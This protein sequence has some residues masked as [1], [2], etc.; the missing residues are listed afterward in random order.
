[1]SKQD[2][3]DEIGAIVGR[4][5]RKRARETERKRQKLERAINKVRT[6]I[7][8][9]ETRFE[10]HEQ[11]GM[12][13]LKVDLKSPR[14]PLILG[15]LALSVLAV[16]GI[17]GTP[18]AGAYQYE[19]FDPI[20]PRVATTIV[21]ALIG[22]TGVTGLYAMFAMWWG[23]RLTI[24]LNAN[25]QFVVFHRARRFVKA[26]GTRNEMHIELRD[27]DEL[28]DGAFPRVRMGFDN[29]EFQFSAGLLSSEEVATLQRLVQR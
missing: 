2:A 26:C 28:A 9:R 10:L 19:H 15:S 16:V 8:R 22:L 3:H 4:R 27:L 21:V 12:R 6:Q 17:V 29:S 11:G 25:G 24:E 7:Q 20:V 13:T 18:M 1:M 5:D 23:D 14:L